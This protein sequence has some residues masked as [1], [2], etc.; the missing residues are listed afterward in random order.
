MNLQFLH[1]RSLM[2]KYNGKGGTTYAVGII[3]NLE[4][5]NEN[6]EV[7]VGRNL[8]VK[9]GVAKCSPSDCFSKKIGRELSTSRLQ[10]ITF[11]VVDIS[12]SLRED[13]SVRTRITLRKEDGSFLVLTQSS[14][15]SNFRVAAI[16]IS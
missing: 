8:G 16:A 7:K 6:E 5:E 1:D 2:S 10:L 12:K 15:N 9:V 4:S 13:A 11:K 14:Q 3:G